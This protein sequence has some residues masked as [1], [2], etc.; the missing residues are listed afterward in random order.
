MNSLTAREKTNQGSRPMNQIACAVLEN[1]SVDFG[2]DSLFIHTA[3]DGWTGENWADWGK[4]IE[5]LAPGELSPR[6]LWVLVHSRSQVI[7]DRIPQNVVWGILDAHVASIFGCNDCQLSLRGS[8]VRLECASGRRM[9]PEKLNTGNIEKRKP[10]LKVEEA[11]CST[12]RDRD[13]PRS[14]K[15]SLGLVPHHRIKRDRKLVE[16][17]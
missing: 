10:Y 7:A 15:R 4:L 12:L 11:L 3:N 13:T 14:G 9:C 5:S 1:L 8:L 6:A 17:H 2:R 16:M